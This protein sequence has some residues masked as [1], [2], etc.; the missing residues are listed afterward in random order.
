MKKLYS[1]EIEGKEKEWSFDIVANPKH[2]EDWRKDGLVVNEIINTVK[3]SRNKSNLFPFTNLS[4]IT[5]F[6]SAT[7]FPLINIFLA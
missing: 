7:C 3:V 1:L 5:R 2:V 6:I 4:L